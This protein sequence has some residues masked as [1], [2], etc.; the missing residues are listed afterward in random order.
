M[1]SGLKQNLVDLEDF[2]NDVEAN[3][4]PAVSF[5]KPDVLLDGVP[6]VPRLR[7]SKPLSPNWLK[8][9]KRQA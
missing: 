5:V 8:P 3:Q 7:C 4:L 1:T 9:Y 2:Y 6:E